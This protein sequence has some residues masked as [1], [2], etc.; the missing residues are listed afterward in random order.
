MREEDREACEE[1]GRLG[2]VGAESGGR[3]SAALEVE[4]GDCVDC[5][6]SG[7]REHVAS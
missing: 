2:G 3:G 1:V 5:V 4:V 7:V 6:R